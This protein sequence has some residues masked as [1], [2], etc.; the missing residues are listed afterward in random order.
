MPLVRRPL[1]ATFVA[2]RPD[3]AGALLALEHGTDSARWEAARSLADFADA[4]PALGHAL[5][6]EAN[7]RVREAIFT[8]L[9]QLGGA[10]SVDAVLPHLRSVDANLRGGALDALKA[11]PEPMRP[12]LAALLNDPDPNIRLLACELAHEV[13]SLQTNLLLAALLEADPEVN[14]CAAALGALAEMGEPE[15][16][17]ALRVCRERFADQPFIHFA[18]ATVRARFGPAP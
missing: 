16:L 7:L 6:A 1:P 3:R 11:M 17:H 4:A 18:A 10:A 12:C 5:G 13:P 8:S 2:D 9:I 14:V 15:I